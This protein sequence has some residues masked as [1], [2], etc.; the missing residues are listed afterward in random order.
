M[1]DSSLVCVSALR[2]V[3]RGLIK[4]NHLHAVEDVTTDSLNSGMILVNNVYYVNSSSEPYEALDLKEL[5]RRK[6]ADQ[7]AEE[8]SEEESAPAATR[9]GRRG[10]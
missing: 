1:G 4:S 5:I 2:W 7:E 3:I 9:G 8:S 10:L 6:R